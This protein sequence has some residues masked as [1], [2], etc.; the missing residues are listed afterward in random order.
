MLEEEP[1]LKAG[2]EAWKKNNPDKLG[3]PQAVL[4][5]IFAHGQR[6]AEAGWR[7]YPVVGLN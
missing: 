7:R 1:A 2:F 6:H 5:F 3:D 4:G